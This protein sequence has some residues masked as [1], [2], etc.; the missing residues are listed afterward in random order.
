MKVAVDQIRSWPHVPIPL[1]RNGKTAPPVSADEPILVHQ[2]THTATRS[3][4]AML[5]QLRM[6]PRTTV[7][8]VRLR[9]ESEH[10][11]RKFVVGDRA[12]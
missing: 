5:A 11:F 6:Q 1:C 10:D 7:R 2:A 4:E 3:E 8:I 12:G 9:V